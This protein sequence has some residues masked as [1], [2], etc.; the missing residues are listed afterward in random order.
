MLDRAPPAA[1]LLVPV[2]TSL[3]RSGLANAGEPLYLRD[4][5]DRRISAAPRSVAAGQVARAGRCLQ[6]VSADPRTADPAAFIVA[7]CSPGR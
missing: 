4:P 2:G 7:P 6:R 1:T 3:T 5:H